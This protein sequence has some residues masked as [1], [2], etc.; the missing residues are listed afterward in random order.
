MKRFLAVLL[1]FSYLIHSSFLMAQETQPA[2]GSPWEE[3]SAEAKKWVFEDLPRHLGNDIK[4]TFWNPWHLLGLAAGTGLVLGVHQA[5]SNIQ[6]KFSGQPMGKTS[7]T[8]IG[9]GTHPAVLGAT[10]LMTLGVS[11]LAHWEKASKTTGTLLEALCVAEAFTLPLKFATQRTRPNGENFSF[12]SAH[13]SGAFALATTTEV[14]YG[15][16]Y[17]IPA[18]LLASLVGVSRLDS[19]SHFA[20]DVV[21]GALLGTLIGLGTAKFHKKEFSKF[22]ITPSLQDDTLSLNLVSPF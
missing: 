14:L 5:D 3:R 12:P 1:I 4:E 21:A 8:I 6:Q 7:D 20:S 16:A 19:N 13:T 10:L 9:A 11:E 17:G 15:P 2:Q 18:Y 22:F